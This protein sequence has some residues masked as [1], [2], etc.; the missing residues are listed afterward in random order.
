ML[1]EGKRRLVSVGGKPI[2][3]AKAPENFDAVELGRVGR[4]EKQGKP[5]R[6]PGGQLVFN[7][8]GFVNRGIIEHKHG[9]LRE[10]SQE[11]GYGQPEEVGGKGG[12]GDK[13]RK[14][15][16]SGGLRARWAPESQHRIAAPAPRSA[17]R[18]TGGWP[19]SCQA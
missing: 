8:P 14:V 16:T 17:V 4:Q 1:Q 12:R 13:A 3:L 10:L 19:R 18:P 7:Q 2:V 11:V 6:S 5:L 9:G 15:L